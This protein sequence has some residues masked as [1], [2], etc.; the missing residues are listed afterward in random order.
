MKILV[1]EKEYNFDKEM[2][3]SELLR[4]LSLNKENIAVAVNVEVVKKEKYETVFVK[5]GDK[6]EIVHFVGGG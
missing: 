3:V 5:D 2:S 4:F 6:V 1:N